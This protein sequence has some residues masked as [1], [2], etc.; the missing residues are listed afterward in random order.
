[1]PPTRAPAR[2]VLIAA[3]MVLACAGPLRAQD[4]EPEAEA[5]TAEKARPKPKPK[6][7]A[8]QPKATTAAAPTQPSAEVASATAAVW[9]A[10]AKTV[11]ESYGDW[12]M[13]CVRPA[14]KTACVVAQSQGD[15]KSGRRRFG[16]ELKPPRDGQAQGVIVMPFGL[17]IEPGV[18]FKLDEQTLGRGAPYSS[19]NGEGCLVTISFPA[20]ATDAMRTAK[21]LTVIGRK[22]TSATGIEAGEP[23]AITVPLAGFPQAFDRAIALSS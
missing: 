18:T 12:T 7:R 11:S 3:L 1:M 20:L 6:R 5:P 19:C 16:I 21:A 8:A 9:P 22:T 23:A 17:A 4:A 15:S 14:D 10:G 13:T 2:S